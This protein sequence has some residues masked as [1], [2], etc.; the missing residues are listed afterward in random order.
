MIFEVLPENNAFYNND[1]RLTQV[2]LPYTIPVALTTLPM[3]QICYNTQLHIYAV[4]LYLYC[5]LT[6][7][8]RNFPCLSSIL[9]GFGHSRSHSVHILHSYHILYTFSSFS[10]FIPHFTCIHNTYTTSQL[11]QFWHNTQTTYAMPTDISQ[12]FLQLTS[13]LHD[14]QTTALTQQ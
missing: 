13:Y 11:S 14:P 10:A 7:L 12:T 9:Y 2:S 8:T 4:F 6:L 3:A 5:I 1:L